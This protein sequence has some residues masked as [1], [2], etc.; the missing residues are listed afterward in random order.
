MI[1]SSSQNFKKVINLI[2]KILDN[3]NGDDDDDEKFSLLLNP[4]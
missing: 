1:K 2:I 4:L 3:F